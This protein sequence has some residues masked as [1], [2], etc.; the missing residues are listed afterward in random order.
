MRSGHGGQVCHLTGLSWHGGHH[1][2]SVL[3]WTFVAGWNSRT[4][5]VHPPNLLVLARDP[6]STID[7]R[8]RRLPT[9][10]RDLGTNLGTR[11]AR[12]G[13]SLPYSRWCDLIT[14]PASIK[15]GSGIVVG[16]A[17]RLLR[18]TT[19]DP[20]LNHIRNCPFLVQLC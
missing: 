4:S 16:T 11:H 7:L 15:K 14:F 3:Y 9:Y 8:L 17:R 5:R 10:S 1:A 18:T 6:C 2:E 19:P 12:C 13:D 20:F